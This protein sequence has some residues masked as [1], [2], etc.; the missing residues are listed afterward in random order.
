MRRI[1]GIAP[2]GFG[3]PSLD[4]L[5]HELP[6]F[7][8]PRLV[9][10]LDPADTASRSFN[11]TGKGWLQL[12]GNH[13]GWFLAETPDAPGIE[14]YAFEFFPGVPTQ[15]I[16]VAT[17]GTGVIKIREWSEEVGG[18]LAA[19][20][21]GRIVPPALET[22]DVIEPSTNIIKSNDPV[23]TFLPQA[24]NRGTVIV[25][26]A[27][28]QSG[29]ANTHSLTVGFTNAVTAGGLNGSQL[30]PGQFFT[31]PA[32]QEIFYIPDGVGADNMT[33]EFDETV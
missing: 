20:G 14:V 24:A 10:V 16:Y 9:G 32:G 3:R 29:A 33:I 27:L 19:G 7:R 15:R 12:A 21:G 8:W 1:P 2:S 18:I 31:F 30:L 25:N 13:S 22:V 4:K 23:Q 28:F 17:V 26:R 6:E 11:I 5:P